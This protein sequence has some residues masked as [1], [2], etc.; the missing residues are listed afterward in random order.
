MLVDGLVGGKDGRAETFRRAVDVVAVPIAIAVGVRQTEMTEEGL[1]GEM[2]GDLSG[3]GSA[4]AVADDKG[5]GFG[6]GIASIFVA[7]ANEAPVRQHR[8]NELICRHKFS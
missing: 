2:A 8:M 4:H 6:A 7:A 5:P 1:G 3:G